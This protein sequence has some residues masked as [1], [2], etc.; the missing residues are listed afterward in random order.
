M[1]DRI[2][3]AEASSLL[4]AASKPDKRRVRGTTRVKYRGLIFDS[5]LERDQYIIQSDRLKR[6]EIR[7]LRRQVRYELQGSNGPILTPTG[8]VMQYW[9]DFVF[10]DITEDRERILDAKGHQ[11]ETS[12]MKLAILA[13][14]GVH[15]ELV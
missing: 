4:T 14:Q 5:K 8:R 2:S 3:A 13:A 7:D 9:A 6:G 11:T 15:V 10:W 1:T 12:V